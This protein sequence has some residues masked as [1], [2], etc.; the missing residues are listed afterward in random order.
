LRFAR[1]PRFFLKRLCDQ[2]PAVDLAYEP[3]QEL[4]PFA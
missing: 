4:G 1:C 2:E 3:E